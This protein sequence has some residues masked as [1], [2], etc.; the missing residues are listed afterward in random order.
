MPSRSEVR[1]SEIANRLFKVDPLLLRLV[2]LATTPPIH[3]QYGL[4]VELS[5]AT[6]RGVPAPAD[7]VADRLD[8]ETR[9]FF[10]VQAVVNASAGNDVEAYESA[11]ELSF[12]AG[13]V[14]RQRAERES[15]MARTEGI[16]YSSIDDLPAELQEDAVDF[17][18]PPSAFTLSAAQIR[19]TN[20]DWES[21]GDIRVVLSHVQAWWTFRLGVPP[22]LAESPEL[23][24]E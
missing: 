1:L 13:L 10:K 14:D 16:D 19:R 20:G 23:R 18:T 9:W 11:Q 24:D 7:V 17:A 5:G 4:V 2:D 6:L 3:V 22:E 12:F 15:F 21:I 8:D